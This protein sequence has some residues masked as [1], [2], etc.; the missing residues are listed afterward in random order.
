[1]LGISRNTVNRTVN[2]I[3]R[4]RKSFYEVSLMTE[5]E[6]NDVLRSMPNSSSRSSRESDYVM[7]DYERLKKELV[8]PGVT[9][10]LLWEEYID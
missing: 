9:L 7:L 5:D 10:Q 1:M 3:I 4:S 8:K 2:A 6:L